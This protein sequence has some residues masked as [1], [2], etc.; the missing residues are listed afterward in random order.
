MGALCIGFANW[1]ELRISLLRSSSE[2]SRVLSSLSRTVF[3]GM[4]GSATDV[5]IVIDGLLEW[6]WM[7][8]SIA[9]TTK[10]HLS[11]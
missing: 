7:K 8:M 2:D 1:I 3:S 5:A 9:I 10:R 6:V 11:K 4:V